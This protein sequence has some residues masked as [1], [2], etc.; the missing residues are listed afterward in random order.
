MFYP[1]PFLGKCSCC[2]ENIDYQDST[3]NDPASSVV[4]S[5]LECQTLCVKFTDRAMCAGFVWSV[6]SGQCA[7]KRSLANPFRNA[8][9]ISGPPRCEGILIHRKHIRLTRHWDFLKFN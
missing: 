5:V 6:L 2:E 1:F 4:G 7:L 8:F 3:I 9:V